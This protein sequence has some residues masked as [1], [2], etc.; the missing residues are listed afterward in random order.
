MKRLK[1]LAFMLAV[2][3]IAS[4][5]TACSR[6]SDAI[7]TDTYVNTLS[8]KFEEIVKKN[9]ELDAIRNSNTNADL[10]GDLNSY[11][12][13]LDT[14]SN[15]YL[16]MRNI[17]PTEG[18]SDEDYIIDISCSG[19][20]NILSQEKALVQYTLDSSDRAAYNSGISDII[21]DYT[22]LYNDIRSSMT[23]IKTNFRNS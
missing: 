13:L 7:D 16:E 10:S 5:L 3:S 19:Q 4:A 20:I 2:F 21:N 12:D 22:S 8:D 14:L 11:L 17:N 15:L 23:K 1:T 9:R 6:I 18:F